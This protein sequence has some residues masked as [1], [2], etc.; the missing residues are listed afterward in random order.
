MKVPTWPFTTSSSDLLSKVLPARLADLGYTDVRIS[1]L[2]VY[3]P[4]TL[5]VMLVAHVDT[6]H[7]TTPCR[8]L[9]YDSSKEIL[10]SPDGLGADDRAGVLAIMELLKFGYRPHVLFTDFE[11]RGALG[12]RS[13]AAQ[14]DAPPVN[15]II[16]LDRL[17]KNDAVF[18]SCDNIEFRQFVSEF[19]WSYAAGTFTDVSILCPAWNIAGVNVSVGYY[20]P[21]SKSELLVVRCLEDTILRVATMCEAEISSPFVY[22]NRPMSVGRSWGVASHH[23]GS[24]ED[25]SQAVYDVRSLSDEVESLS[26]RRVVSPASRSTPAVSSPVGSSSQGTTPPT[27]DIKVTNDKPQVEHRKTKVPAYMA[28]TDRQGVPLYGL[29]RTEVE[30]SIAAYRQKDI[31]CARLSSQ[32]LVD[33]IGHD[34]SHWTNWLLRHRDMVQDMALLCLIKAVRELHMQG[35]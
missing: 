35:D 2:Y 17:G 9:Y 13:A 20:F 16:E 8:D 7:N 26:S 19:G 29:G 23:W 32:D 10:W 24:Y 12:A 22:S 33:S 27:K 15:Y 28:L 3:S 21:H 14:L 31:I 5:P 1:P 25:Y 18:Y 11:E 6:V 34:T 30:E 4:G